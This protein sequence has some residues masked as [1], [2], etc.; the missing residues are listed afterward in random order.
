MATVSEIALLSAE[1]NKLKKNE[2]I[3]I[4]L[5]FKLPATV[6]N[7][8]LMNYV[9]KFGG[10]DVKQGSD[11]VDKLHNTSENKI[12]I[13]CEQLA[14][15]HSVSKKELDCS[16]KKSEAIPQKTFSAALKSNRGNTE[17]K[18]DKYKENKNASG[19]SKWNPPNATPSLSLTDRHS[20]PIGLITLVVPNP[21]ISDDIDKKLV[22]HSDSD[23]DSLTKIK[24]SEKRKRR[25]KVDEK[26]WISKKI[27]QG[28]EKGERY[29]GKEKEEDCWTHIKPKEA[30]S[31]ETRCSCEIGKYRTSKCETIDEYVRPRYQNT[32]ETTKRAETFVYHVHDGEVKVCRNLFLNTSDSGRWTVQNWRQEH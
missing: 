27:K 32:K 6:N 17:Q 19:D 10:S 25:V 1:L 23:S 29:F 30:R 7:V 14:K 31:I 18:H 2:L 26:K 24:N 9:S 4:I 15:D 22:P 8:Q 12:C 13:H 20:S 11:D 21:P 28:R 3:D 5:T 16:C